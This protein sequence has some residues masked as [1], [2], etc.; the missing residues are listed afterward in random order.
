MKRSS[1][2]AVAASTLAE[3]TIGDAARRIAARLGMLRAAMEGAA[4]EPLGGNG[5][6]RAAPPGADRDL[7]PAVCLSSQ[8]FWSGFSDFLV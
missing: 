5:T 2:T 3:L 7:P 4:A 1:E 8:T 6:A